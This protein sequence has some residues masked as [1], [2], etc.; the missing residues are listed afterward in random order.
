MKNYVIALLIAI[1]LTLFFMFTKYDSWTL[2]EF[3]NALTITSLIMIIIGATLFISGQGFFY[4]IAY[5]FRRFF[6]KT[7]KKWQMLNEPDEEYVVNKHSFSLTV[8]LLLL[9]AGIF[10][11]VLIVSFAFY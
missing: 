10:M 3:I 5:S 4:G 8:P 6:K 11:I 1:I 7:S 2:L 9:G